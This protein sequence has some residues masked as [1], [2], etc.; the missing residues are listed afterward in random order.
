MSP[1]SN[2]IPLGLKSCS[3]AQRMAWWIFTILPSWTRKKHCTRPST[4]VHQST[5]LISSVTLTSLLCLTM[6]SFPC[7]NWWEILKKGL[8]NLPQLTL[9]IWEKNWERNTLQM[10]WGDRMVVQ[11]LASEPTGMFSPAWDIKDGANGAKAEKA[12]IWS[13]SR[14]IPLGLLHWTQKSLW[15]APM[16]LRSS[17]LFAF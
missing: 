1:S 8:R 15:E 3:Q 4:I 10:F 5:T 16:D 7:M 6:R 9:E 17:G 11:L 14:I 2:S 13:N 12:S